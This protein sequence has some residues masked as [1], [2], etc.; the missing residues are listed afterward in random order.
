MIE[1]IVHDV[2]VRI[3]KDVRWPGPDPHRRILLKERGGAR[4]LHVFA[5][6][7]EGDAIALHL[8]GKLP[9]RPMIYE[10]AAQLITLGRLTVL[11]AVILDLDHEAALWVQAGDGAERSIRMNP[12]DAINLALRAGAPILADE[13]LLE[14]YGIPEAELWTTL[15][16]EN[17]QWQQH[18]AQHMFMAPEARLDFP[19]ESE[20]EWRS[21][22][23]PEWRLIN[24]AP[25]ELE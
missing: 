9:A 16:E 6:A 4:Y 22:V 21:I 5:G 17:R 19:D 14:E 24:P 25:P 7:D 18:L 23:P 2:I 20:M 15:D 1:L 12:P 10:S 11:R 3:H 13:K 8:S